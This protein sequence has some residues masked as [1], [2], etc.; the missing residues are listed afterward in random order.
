[1]DPAVIFTNLPVV[2]SAVQSEFSVK[3]CGQTSLG[4]KFLLGKTARIRSFPDSFSVSHYERSF[5]SPPVLAVLPT[6]LG[7][8]SC[9]PTQLVCFALRSPACGAVKRF[10]EGEER[11]AEK[12]CIEP[13]SG[14]SSAHPRA[15]SVI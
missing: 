8:V 10:G 5:V 9:Y 2:R 11:T 14:N 7:G 13:F 12:L 1:M 6:E 4:G 3:L 15:L